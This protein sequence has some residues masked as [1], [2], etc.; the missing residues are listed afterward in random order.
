M[1]SKNC[2]RCKTAG[3]ENLFCIFQ[4]NA[5]S[6]IVG[7]K[8]QSINLSTCIVT[9][10]E[11]RK[12]RKVLLKAAAAERIWILVSSSLKKMVTE[13]TNY[14]PLSRGNNDWDEKSNLQQTNSLLMDCGP[15]INT[16]L[17]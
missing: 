13:R 1:F 3:S 15:C 10:F 16:I 17:W 2:F 4:V 14:G 11:Q 8:H 12:D 5:F 7:V 9:K 6:A